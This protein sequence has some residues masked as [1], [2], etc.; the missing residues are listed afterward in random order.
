MVRVAVQEGQN[1]A[2]RAAGQGDREDH[3]VAQEVA[4]VVQAEVHYVGNQE[5]ARADQVVAQE[6]YDAAHSELTDALEEASAIFD[7]EF[8]VHLIKIVVYFK[9]GLFLTD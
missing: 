3:Q 5:R 8:E 6:H 1:S 2:V 4:L 7:L 9:Y